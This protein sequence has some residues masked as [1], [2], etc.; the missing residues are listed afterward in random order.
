MNDGR[1]GGCWMQEALR[2]EEFVILRERHLGGF[3][4]ETLVHEG[5]TV[6]ASIRYVLRGPLLVRTAGSGVELRAGDA[7]VSAM[8][9]ATPARS[10][11]MDSDMIQLTWRCRGARPQEGRFRPSAR[12]SSLF[13]RLAAS[14]SHGDRVSAVR[15]AVDV[16]D[17]LR[18]EGIPL[19][20]AALERASDVSFD[21]KE[22]SRAIASA[23]PLWSHPTSAD[24]ARALGVCEPHALRRTNLHFRKYYRCVSSWRDYLRCNRLYF[25]SFFMGR[26][27][28]RTEDVARALGFRSPTSFCHAFHIGG[29]GSPQRV[30][31]ELLAS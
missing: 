7:L 2:N 22:I 1:D 17:A 20:T 19:D 5:A 10:L 31:R 9:G 29:L 27:G 28:A 30:Q 8:H 14:L 18:A 4:D 6:C 16:F 21:T 12:A 23:V 11:T 13:L 3:F 25:G 24:L 26:P 15:A